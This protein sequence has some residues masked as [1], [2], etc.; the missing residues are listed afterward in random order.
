[1]ASACPLPNLQRGAGPGHP[2]PTAAS[3]VPADWT[4]AQL[5]SYLIGVRH[6]RLFPALP[7]VAHTGLRRSEVA[8]LK[9]GDLDTLAATL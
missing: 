7:L 4:A 6:V 5:A 3:A 1:M 8:R 2:A 9:W